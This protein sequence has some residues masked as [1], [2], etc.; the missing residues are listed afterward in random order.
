MELSF[1]RIWGKK[2]CEKMKR[3]VAKKRNDGGCE[4]GK[5]IGRMVIKKDTSRGMKK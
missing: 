5:K 1:G 2:E 3:K 4:P